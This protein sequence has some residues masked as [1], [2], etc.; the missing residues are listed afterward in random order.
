MGAYGPDR[1]TGEGRERQAAAVDGQ[2]GGQLL[3]LYI[4]WEWSL[5]APFWGIHR[6]AFSAHSYAL[7]APLAPRCGGLEWRR[8]EGAWG[9]LFLRHA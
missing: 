3:G 7:T 9:I 6:M 1:G 8:L 4:V 5:A 2:A